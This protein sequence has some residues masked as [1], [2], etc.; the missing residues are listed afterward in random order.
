MRELCDLKVFVDTDADIRLVRRIR[1]DM[2]TRGRPLDEI[3]EQYVT[4]VQSHAPRVR[5][6][7]KRSPMW[8]SRAA[9]TTGRDRD[10]RR[11]RIPAALERNPVRDA[12]ARRRARAR[13][14]RRAGHRRARRLPP[15]QGRAIA[16]RTARHRARTR[17]DAAREEHPAL[18]V[19]DL[20]LPG[21][22]GFDVL[23]KL[24]AHDATRDV[25]VLMLTARRRSPTASAGSSLG[26]DDY[27]TKPFSPAELVLRVGAILRRVGG[28][29]GATRHARDR[30]RD[31]SIA[32]RTPSR[33]RG[34]RRAHAHRIQAAPHARRAPRTRAGTRPPAAR[35]CG[36]PRPTSRRARWTCTCSACAPSSARRAT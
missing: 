5:G 28:G 2:R 7:Q 33:S 8:S 17:C 35:P 23:E 9:D 32:R 18:V 1:R 29:A 12:A 25:A 20:M 21:M 11:A 10:G 4:T 13:R 19:L 34:A 36:M 6:A 22:S 24:R 27:L 16:S 3:L 30:P 15:G 14:G 26:A 31:A